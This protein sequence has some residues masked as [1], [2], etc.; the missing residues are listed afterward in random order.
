MPNLHKRYNVCEPTVEGVSGWHYSSD[1][2]G[3]LYFCG[4]CPFDEGSN[5]SSYLPKV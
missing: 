2:L 4:C 1:P 5:L 3:P